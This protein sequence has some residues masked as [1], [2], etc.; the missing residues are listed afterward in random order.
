VVFK[1]RLWII[2]IPTSTPKSGTGGPAQVVESSGVSDLTSLEGWVISTGLE[3]CKYSASHCTHNGSSTLL[4]VSTCPTRPRP[5]ALLPCYPKNGPS[6][7]VCVFT[8]LA[9]VQQVS[10]L[11]R[12][13]P[14]TT[15][16]A[17]WPHARVCLTEPSQPSGARALL[18]FV[19]EYYG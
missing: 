15:I 12:L 8:D 18:S 11:L 2:Y 3:T 17:S 5:S 14:T 9:D 19:I 6:I 1:F 4:T 10:A 7:L 16:S 13:T